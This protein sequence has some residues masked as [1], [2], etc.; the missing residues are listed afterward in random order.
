MVTR[1]DVVVVRVQRSAAYAEVVTDFRDR[2]CVLAYRVELGQPRDLDAGVALLHE[3]PQLH[4]REAAS[5]GSAASQCWPSST[6]QA[7]PTSASR[8]PS[9]SSW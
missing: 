2:L 4:A 9:T 3:G 6:Q 1:V 7:H 5:I 8:W